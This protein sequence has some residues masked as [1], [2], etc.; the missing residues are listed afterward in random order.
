MKNIIIAFLLLPMISLSQTST[1]RSSSQSSSYPSSSSSSRSNIIPSNENNVSSWRN[2][3]PKEFNKPQVKQNTNIII[4]EPWFGGFNRWNTW[5]APSFGWNNWSPIYYWNDWGYR[6]PAR[7][8]FFDNGRQ[9]TIKG[10]KPVI[11]FGLHHTTNSQIGAFFSIGTKGYF[12]FDF[13][14]TYERDHSTYFPYGT[15]ALVD[16]P[17]INDL[18]KQRSFYFG[19]GKRIKRFGFH[20]MLGIANERIL[21]RGKDDIGEITFP[22]SND[23]FITTKVGVLK[24][25]RSLSVKIDYD[26]VIR[27]GQMGLGINF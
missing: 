22:K 10:K 27:Y 23:T 20:G 26:P 11:N 7:I 8:Y 12:I 16:F 17:M 5:G 9:D 3:P 6:Q 1:W 18:V 21:F 15:L 24:D 13:N 2:S 25:F 14:S 19:G 4:H